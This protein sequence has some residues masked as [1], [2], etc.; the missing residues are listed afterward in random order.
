M[1]PL[2]VVS[3][4]EIM[5][6]LTTHFSLNSEQNSA[7][8][9]MFFTQKILIFCCFLT[10]NFAVLGQSITGKITDEETVKPLNSANIVLVGTARGT[11]SNS[12]GDFT[13]KNLAKG[14]ANRMEN[15][16]IPLRN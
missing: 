8:S 6:K 9:C 1:T 15:A 14:W 16:A 13:L 3:F 4:L 10:A 11:Q 7:F 12:Q 2:S 5:K